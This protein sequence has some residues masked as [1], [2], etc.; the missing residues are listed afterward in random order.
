MTGD[1]TIS[2]RVRGDAPAVSV[3][4]YPAM[5]GE[6]THCQVLV[7]G[8]GQPIYLYGE[9]VWE[10]VDFL[11]RLAAAVADAPAQVIGADAEGG[12]VSA[13]L[14]NVAFFERLTNTLLFMVDP[15]LST[16]VLQRMRTAAL[17]LC[18]KLDDA[19]KQP[20]HRPHCGQQVFTLSGICTCVLPPDHEG[21]CTPWV[22]G[23]A[24]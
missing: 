24:A 9:T 10:V 20:Q 21:D 11:D 5:A 18:G 4:Q 17:M 14:D 19:L 7:T 15:D 8:Q 1:V 12:S 3:R 23:S 6:G 16:S 22:S 2:I 13:A